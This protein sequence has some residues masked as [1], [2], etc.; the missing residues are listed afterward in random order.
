MAWGARSGLKLKYLSPIANMLP[1]RN[2]LGSPF[3]GRNYSPSRIW[4]GGVVFVEDACRNAHAG[5][6]Y[7]PLHTEGVSS[8][9]TSRRIARGEMR[10]KYE[11]GVRA[12]RG[13]RV[14]GYSSPV[15][16]STS[17]GCLSCLP[18][19]VSKRLGAS[20]RQNAPKTKDAERLTV[21]ITRNLLQRLTKRGAV[22]EKIPPAQSRGM[23]GGGGIRTHEGYS[24]YTISSRA[25]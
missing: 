20:K 15:C 5:R 10:N 18:K 1:S 14:D 3:E 16:F 12:V 4:A 8:R 2:G 7:P 6:D 11:H 19:N 13:W 23:G 25:H 17:R 22:S 21:V 24:P 9:L